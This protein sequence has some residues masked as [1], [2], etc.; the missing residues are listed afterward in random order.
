MKIGFKKY[1]RYMAENV[2]SVILA[3][4]FGCTRQVSCIPCKTHGTAAYG[5]PLVCVET[6]APLQILENLELMVSG[7]TRVFYSAIAG[8]RTRCDIRGNGLSTL[9]GI[10]H[11]N[12]ELL[13]KTL[14][15]D[16][17]M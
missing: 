17:S 8:W 11:V 4:S 6:M 2:L 3:N 16:V 14:P 5:L 15:T 12:G 7:G 1:M 10:L 13:C 9:S